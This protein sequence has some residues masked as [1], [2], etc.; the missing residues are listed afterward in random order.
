MTKPAHKTE[1]ANHTKNMR[2]H[3]VAFTGKERDEETGYGYF[4]ARYIDHELMTGWLSVDP[5]ADKYPNISPYAYCNWN[6]VKL[7][8]PDGMEIDVSG[9][10]E[11][12]QKRLVS[13]LS[14]LTGLSLYVE[15]GKLNYRKGKDGNAIVEQSGSQ[16][17]RMDLIEAIDKKNE[18]ES[19][20]VIGVRTS[21]VKCEGGQNDN[22][23][24]GV[25]NM[26]CSKMQEEEDAQTYG[27]GLVFLHELRH[28]VTGEHDPDRSGYDYNVFGDPNSLK[29]GSI[30][31]RVNEYRRELGMP[32][33]IQ[34]VS[35]DGK[36]PFLDVKYNVTPQNI[37][38]HVIWKKDN[39][40]R[41]E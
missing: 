17:A 19:N 1:G 25:V 32:I 18:D 15:G 29:T 41:Y 12:I 31:D 14:T 23:K 4:G 36:V 37:R 22:K 5:L 20:Y 33:R 38:R 40:K 30:V 26:Y 3:R 8:D 9:L 10:S 34:Y 28:A 11:A 35:K 21:S 2:F 6:P 7:V 27:M 39:S 13:C 24:G 16:T